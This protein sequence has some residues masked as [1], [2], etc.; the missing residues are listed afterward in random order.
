[1]AGLFASQ[2]GIVGKRKGDPKEP[3]PVFLGQRVNRGS[4]VFLEADCGVKLYLILGQVFD[5]HEHRKNVSDE[6]ALERRDLLIG[7]DGTIA[8]SWRG[9]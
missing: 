7:H 8:A 6:G 1:M 4:N 2:V 9:P 3:G 5:G